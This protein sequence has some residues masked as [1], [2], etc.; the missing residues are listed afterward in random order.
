MRGDNDKCGGE[1]QYFR[2]RMCSNLYRHHE[3]LDTTE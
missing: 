1:N 2:S 3:G